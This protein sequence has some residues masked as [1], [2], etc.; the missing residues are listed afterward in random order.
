MYVALA[1]VTPDFVAIVIPIA[2]GSRGRVRRR[3]RASRPQPAALAGDTT[4]EA[5]HV[6]QSRR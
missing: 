1:S 2:A 3:L 5:S 4:H 6:A